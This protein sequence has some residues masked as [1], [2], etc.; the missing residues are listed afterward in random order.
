MPPLRQLPK[1]DNINGDKNEKSKRLQD[2]KRPR[3]ERDVVTKE[4]ADATY[5]TV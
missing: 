2:V 4:Y 1:P 3:K 5:A